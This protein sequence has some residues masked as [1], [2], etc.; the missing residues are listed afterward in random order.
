[1]AS[2]N[3]GG[4]RLEFCGSCRKSCFVV[5]LKDETSFGGPHSWTHKQKDSMKPTELLH[6]NPPNS[7]SNVFSMG[8]LCAMRAS[9]G[10]EHETNESR[11]IEK[12]VGLEEMGHQE[13]T[14]NVLMG[15][16]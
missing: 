14:G 2:L 5:S 8:T 4:H 7:C 13:I 16:R 6:S 12:T 1:M 11:S 3:V 9:G 10:N 15:G